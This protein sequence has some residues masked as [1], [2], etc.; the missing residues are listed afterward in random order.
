MIINGNAGEALNDLVETSLM[1]NADFPFYADGQYQY[2]EI[3]NVEL[4]TGILNSIVMLGR[5]NE[6]DLSEGAVQKI[7]RTKSEYEY[8]IV[9]INGRYWYKQTAGIAS[10]PFYPD[11][12]SE[13]L[14][15]A[16]AHKVKI[17]LYSQTLFIP[18]NI[19]YDIAIW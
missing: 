8:N 5:G 7:Y 9:T 4:S 11:D 15:D 16:T 2:L 18:R 14:Y 19:Y 17:L 10:A 1:L 13:I 6:S 12:A 3:P